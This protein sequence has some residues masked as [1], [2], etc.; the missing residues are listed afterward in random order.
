MDKTEAII[1]SKKYLD[2]L[3]NEDFGVEKA[4]LYGSYAKGTFHKYSDIDLAIVLKEIKDYYVMQL[5]LMKLTI[6]IDTIIEPHPFAKEDFNM[7]NPSAIE[8]LKTGI[9]IK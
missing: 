6:N 5:K 2:Y 1:L 7:E 3:K 9:E 8:V 4:F